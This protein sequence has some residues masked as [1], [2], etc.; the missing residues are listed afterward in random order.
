MF[1]GQKRKRKGDPPRVTV[2]KYTE[3][4]FCLLSQNTDRTPKD[5]TILLQAGLGRRTV[6]IADNAIHTEI[7]RTLLLNYPKMRSLCGGWLLQKASG[8]SGQRRITPLPQGSEG[9]TTKIL[10]T[11]SNGG[12][13]VIYIIP[14][15]E[16]T[17]TTPLPYDAEEFQHMPKHACMSCGQSVPLPLLQ[18]HID[19]CGDETCL[20]CGEQVSTSVIEYHASTCGE[21]LSCDHG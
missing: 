4:Q 7:S 20:V 12:K 18:F 16:R 15:Q 19:S 14:L 6:N 9:Y 2:C 13:N 3:I 21:R 17:D 1:S 5:E 8:G 11:S 10:K